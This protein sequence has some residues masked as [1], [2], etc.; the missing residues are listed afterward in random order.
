MLFRL[1]SFFLYWKYSS[2]LKIKIVVGPFQEQ[3]KIR[4]AVNYYSSVHFVLKAS[5]PMS[6]QLCF[7]GITFAKSILSYTGR[8]FCRIDINVVS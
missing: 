6:I 4:M 8:D 3:M 2:L 5:S 7:N 1:K